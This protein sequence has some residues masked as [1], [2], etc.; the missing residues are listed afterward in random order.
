MTER[1]ITVRIDPSAGSSTGK[2][3]GTG[4]NFD[5]DGA[6]KRC[7]DCAETIK[8]EAKVC[9]YCG[10]Q[11]SDDEMEQARSRARA[12]WQPPVP[13]QEITL[14]Q[15]SAVTVTSKYV[16]TKDKRVAIAD[17]QPI[18]SIQQKSGNRFELY[19]LDARGG[20]LHHLFADKSTLEVLMQVGQAINRAIQMQHGESPTASTIQL[21]SKSQTMG[22]WAW[23]FIIAAAIVLAVIV[24]QL[25]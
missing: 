15:G 8:L 13:Q 23:V 9:R 7:P 4:Q 20:E 18:Q 17:I 14:Y 3:S 25:G 24:L 11:F 6:T 16:T 21:I 19:L 22:C 5:P 10:R 2:P 1:D 12:E